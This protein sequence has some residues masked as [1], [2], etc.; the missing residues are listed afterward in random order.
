MAPRMAQD[1]E[2]DFRTQPDRNRRPDRLSAVM[3][4]AL[5]TL[6]LAV[7]A[8]AQTGG[9]QQ[10]P[11][12]RPDAGHI[13][14][15]PAAAPA[16]PPKKEGFFDALGR[17][18]DRSAADFNANVDKMKGQIEALNERTAKAARDAASAT[19]DATDALV[20]LPNTRIVEG[21]ERCDIAPNGSPD[22]NAAAE[23]ICRSK[24]FT[25]GKSASIEQARKCSARALLSRSDEDCTN[26]TIV[27]RAACQ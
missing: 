10:Q 4:A 16:P 9:V 21:R 23:T 17:W 27:T 12:S 18:W 22:C 11:G 25:I 13:V 15:P 19:R 3:A 5:L 20:R 6:A 7:D 8:R 14:A 2:L 1:R 24:G 26:E